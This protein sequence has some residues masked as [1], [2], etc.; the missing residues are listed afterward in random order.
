MVNEK[1]PILRESV[2]SA[3]S[4]GT[5]STTFLMVLRYVWYQLKVKKMF[6]VEYPLPKLDTLIVSAS[7]FF[8]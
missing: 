8:A 4:K 6:D 2:I 5:V 1:A 3:Y 7:L